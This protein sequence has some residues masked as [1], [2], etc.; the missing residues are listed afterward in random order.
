MQHDRKKDKVSLGMF[1][2]IGIALGT[3]IG[4][5]IGNVGVGMVFGVAAGTLLNLLAFYRE[6]GK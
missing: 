4:A 6:Q 2:P 3:G 5:L 1:L